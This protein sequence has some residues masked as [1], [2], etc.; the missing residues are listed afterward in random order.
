MSLDEPLMTV[1]CRNFEV[2]PEICGLTCGV[3]VSLNDMN[4]TGWI[5][6]VLDYGEGE[7]FVVLRS[8]QEHGRHADPYCSLS[9]F[10][11]FHQAHEG[12]PGVAHDH[13]H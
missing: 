13:D 12:R 10:E 7:W 9:C 11:S 4:G 2:D 8:C 6:R 3:P 1:R 5:N